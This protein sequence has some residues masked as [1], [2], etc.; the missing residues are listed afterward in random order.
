[1]DM[2]ESIN[3]KGFSTDSF[4]F[5]S[6]LVVISGFMYAVKIVLCLGVF[7]CC[8]PNWQSSN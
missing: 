8:L 7:C 2:L 1:M 5:F 4:V 6:L 3:H